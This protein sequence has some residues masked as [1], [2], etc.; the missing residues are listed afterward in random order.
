MST[1]EITLAILAAVLGG[2]GLGTLITVPAKRPNTDA[3]TDGI[4]H[5][6]S[7]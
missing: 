5:H 7:A 1:L 6:G 4:T 3:E 2:G